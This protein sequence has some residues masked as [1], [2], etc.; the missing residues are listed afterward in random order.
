MGGVSVFVRSEIDKFVTIVCENSH[1]YESVNS[2]CA[3]IKVLEHL[4]IDND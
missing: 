3:G 1:F 4:L 2:H